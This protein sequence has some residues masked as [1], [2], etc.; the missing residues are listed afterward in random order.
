[1]LVLLQE[2]SSHTLKVGHICPDIRV[3]GVNNHFSVGRTGNFN[4]AVGKTGSWWCTLPCIAVADVL[5][6]GE[7]VGK[8]SSVKFGLTGHASLQQFLA[9]LVECAVEKSQEDGGFL[10][11]DLAGLVIERSE[12]V[13]LT[14]DV[15]LVLCHCFF[16]LFGV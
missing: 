8:F 5:G 11:D 14:E 1:M 9:S 7:E 2:A 13:D 6:L 3:Q 10:G 12:D 16:L 4:S 15:L